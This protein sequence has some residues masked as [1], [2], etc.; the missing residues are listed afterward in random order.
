MFKKKEICKHEFVTEKRIFGDIEKYY[1]VCVKCSIET[2]E[3]T[4]DVCNHE[5]Y[6][7][8]EFDTEVDSSKSNNILTRHIVI[9]KCSKC[10]KLDTIR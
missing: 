2:L 8:K 4:R 7:D 5:W 3:A 6:F 9:Y 1:R 10:N